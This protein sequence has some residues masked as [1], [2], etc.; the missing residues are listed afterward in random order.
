MRVL[1]IRI[2]SIVLFPPALNLVDA[3]SS[4]GH[5]VTLIANDALLLPKAIRDRPNVN[6]VDL[7]PMPPFP[8]SVLHGFEARRII[9]SYLDDNHDRFDVVWTTTDLAARD[10]GDRV[11]DMCHVMQMSELVESVPLYTQGNI[12][13]KS[14][15]TIEYAQQAFRVVVPEY[16]RAHIQKTWWDL[17]AT[18][19]VLPNKPSLGNVPPAH[20]VSPQIDETLSREEKKIL[21]YQGVYASDRNLKPFAESLEYLGGEYALYLMGKPIGDKQKQLVL[22]LCDQYDDVHYLGFVAAPNHLSFTH[23]GRI[24][25]LP[26]VPSSADRYSKL[27]ALYC[28]PNKIWEY[29]YFGLPMVGS[30][31][32]GLTHAFREHD[33]GITTNCEDPRAIAEAIRHIEERYDQMSANSQQFFDHVDTI[34]IVDSIMQ[35]AE[36]HLK[37]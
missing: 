20:E 3:L 36:S 14:R 1:V 16:N 22:D 32:P 33:M 21:L 4:L 10:A 23:Y 19:T 31:V 18:P 5:E 13:L 12:P 8:V 28:A 35:D 29:A 6:L 11:L 37:R 17:P 2:D 24:G 25:L 9:R 15:R 30:D 34:A 7:G 26:Y 27:N